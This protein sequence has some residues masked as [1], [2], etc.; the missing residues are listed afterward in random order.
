MGPPVGNSIEKIES[1]ML[2]DPWHIGQIERSWIMAK[3]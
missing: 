1:V 2:I 3:T